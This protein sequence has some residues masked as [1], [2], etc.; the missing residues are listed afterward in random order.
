MLPLVL[1]KIAR[2]PMLSAFL[3]TGLVVA[4]AL[5]ASIPLYTNGVLQSYLVRDLEDSQ[6]TSGSYP[7]SYY[8]SRKFTHFGSGGGALEDYPATSKL[9][10]RVL[11]GQIPLETLAQSRRLT[12]EFLDVEPEERRE[13]EVKP[14]SPNLVGMDS[15]EAHVKVLRGRAYATERV[16]GVYEAMVT[17]QGLRDLD[18]RLGEVVLVRDTA[19]RVAEK[20]RV[21]IVGTFVPAAAG[22]PYWYPPWAGTSSSVT[23]PNTN[24]LFVDAALLERDLILA[25]GFP[26]IGA[27]WY[28]AYDHRSVDFSGLG[29]LLSVIRA[30]R[31]MADEQ[32]FTL[33]APMLPILERYRTREKELRITLTLLESPVLLMVLFYL[34]MVSRLLVESEKNDIAVLKSRGGGSGQIFAM[35]AVESLLY[36]AV[37]FALGPPLGLLACRILGSSSGFLELVHR[38]ALPVSLGPSAYAFAGLGLVLFVAAIL[39]PA[40]RGARTTIVIHKQA[41]SRKRGELVWRRY[42][43]D[44]ILLALA[45]YGYWDFHSQK[46]ILAVTGARGTDLPVDPLFFLI[47]VLFLLG[48]GLLFIRLFPL[49]VR[50]IFRIGRR[51]W[52]PELYASFINVSRS[53]SQEQ[54]VIIFLILTVGVGVYS[55]GTARSLDSA[56]R[57]RVR[58]SIGAD[59]NLMPFWWTEHS[60]ADVV[61][62]D[63][64]PSPDAPIARR[65]PPFEAFATLPGVGAATR[66]LRKSSVRGRSPEG[67]RFSAMLLAIVP[68]E[69]GAVAWHRADLL[70]AELAGYL[71]V[72]ARRP[73]SILIS[74]S[75]AE[76]YRIAP[77]DR[78]DVSLGA[79]GQMVGRVAAVIDY[80]A[81]YNP[82]LEGERGEPAHLIVADY[83]YVR[84][85][86]PLEPYEIWIRRDASVDSQTLYDALSSGGMRLVRFRDAE[87]EIVTARANP[88][89]QGMNGVLT[90]GFIVSLAI[91]LSGFLT[92][93]IVS[94]RSRVLQ[95]GVLRA[96]GL[97]RMRL[98]SMLGWEQLLI[99]GSAVVAG[100]LIGGLTTTLF[101]P[102]LGVLTAAADQVPPMRVGIETR[103]F[104]TIVVFSAGM[105]V[106]ALAILGAS[107]SRVRMA[108][109]IKLGED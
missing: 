16:D 77:G 29:R 13:D 38:T 47:S 72:L 83:A 108:Q 60:A 21:R 68:R 45:G 101:V 94:I 74:R 95:F 86:Q 32:G 63:A 48:A 58:Y 103:D 93:W 102:L 15:L 96:M 97:S 105:I 90:L 39:V 70:P 85:L 84:T 99:S 57:D 82:H 17:E 98:L 19:E 65:E 18:L 27:E 53:I 28:T 41:Q 37:A 80:W 30:Q 71:R 46:R 88:F 100:V 59:I 11:A 12:L 109:A 73:D 34:S 24:C 23:S 51:F 8:V 26:F 43:L 91:C 2:N 14:R 33:D 61:N 50:V 76:T 81:T 7:G 87:Q 55:S 67:G 62:R 20:I 5:I 42:Y 35:Y 54:F 25:K 4:S 10:T 52:P 78:I 69:Y 40:S 104:R 107:V 56:T 44:L 36:G 22:D 66:V 31:R 92:Y 49:L 106:L 79:D 6:N 3:V 64:G 75:I 89:L 1:R 9:V